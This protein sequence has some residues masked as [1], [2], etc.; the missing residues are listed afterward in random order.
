MHTSA[1]TE[2]Q[3]PF[4]RERQ[5]QRS[6]PRAQS[7][8]KQRRLSCTYNNNNSNREVNGEEE[9]NRME[10]WPSR[11]ICDY[12]CVSSFNQSSFFLFKFIC[13]LCY[14]LV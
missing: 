11:M 3:S 6:G 1:H 10:M 12:S 14:L 2:Q 4:T 9:E 5:Q 13:S 8:K 7:K